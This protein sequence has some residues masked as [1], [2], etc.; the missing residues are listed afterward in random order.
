M[1]FFVYILSC[2]ELPIQPYLPACVGGIA[3][4]KSLLR[5]LLATLTSLVA[6]F[7]GLFLGFF[8]LIIN[9]ATGGAGCR[10]N[11]QSHGCV[12]RNRANNSTGC[13]VHASAAQGALLGIRHASTSTALAIAGSSNTITNNKLI[14][15]CFMEISPFLYFWFRGSTFKGSGLS[16]PPSL[17]APAFATQGIELNSVPKLFLL[18]FRFTTPLKIIDDNNRTLKLAAFSFVVD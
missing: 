16:C 15:L 8:V 10:T 11:G 4:C 14:I 3:L 12:T 17:N 5:G 6:F 18:T 7:I 13:S 2:L 9:I 1:K